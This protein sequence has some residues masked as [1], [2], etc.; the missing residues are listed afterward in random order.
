M[1]LRIVHHAVIDLEYHVDQQEE[2]EPRD[3]GERGVFLMPRRYQED[4]VHQEDASGGDGENRD[5]IP[6]RDVP[7]VH[8]FCIM[9]RDNGEEEHEHQRDDRPGRLQFPTVHPDQPEDD[10]GGDLHEH[11]YGAYQRRE[12]AAPFHACI[13][14]YGTDHEYER[15]VQE[16]HCRR[17]YGYAQDGNRL[18]DVIDSPCRKTQRVFRRAGKERLH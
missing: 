12:D 2:Q 5:G 8:A 17:G 11:P 9:P 10:V 18:Q 1:G 4:I 6:E 13:V 3:D 15:H 16:K 7:P 14:G